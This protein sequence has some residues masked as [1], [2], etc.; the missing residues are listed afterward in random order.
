MPS[1]ETLLTDVPHRQVVLGSTVQQTHVVTIERIVQSA[2]DHRGRC[3]LEHSLQH[4]VEVAVQAAR[5]L[6]RCSHPLTVSPT[7]PILRTAHHDTQTTV[8]VVLAS[9]DNHR[10]L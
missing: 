5:L 8:D 7:H 1:E 3:F 4:T 6:H 2:A 9:L 10:F